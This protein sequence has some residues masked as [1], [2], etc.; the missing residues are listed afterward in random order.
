MPSTPYRKPPLQIIGYVKDPSTYDELAFETAIRGE[1]ENST[2]KL[3][4][5]D[6]L[7]I[8]TLLIQMQALLEAHTKILEEGQ[9]ATY[10]PGI[11]TSPWT[12]IR[13][14]CTDKI[15]KILGELALVAKGRP[16][17]QNKPT[18]VDELFA[19]A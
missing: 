10:G 2:G 12:K 16:K 1:V 3:S 15:I 11:T 5:S 19:T 18:E 7:L 17:K 4:P 14:E 6:E 13:N 9:L 8:G